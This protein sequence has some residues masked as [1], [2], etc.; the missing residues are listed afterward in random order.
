[1]SGLI[2]IHDRDPARRRALREAF[3]AGFFT[4]AEAA[5]PEAAIALA[6]RRRICLAALEPDAPAPGGAAL[7]RA[8]K[9]HPGFGAAPI[10]PTAAFRRGPEG[11]E[12]RRR[13]ADAGADMTT[14]PGAG[15]LLHAEVRS[16]LRLKTMSDELERRRRTARDLGL[17]GGE[18]ASADGPARR[19][20]I[21][22]VA[23]ASPRASALAA[24]LESKLDAA[25][26]IA[27]A[28][29]AAFRT[30]AFVSPDAI[31]VTDPAGAAGPQGGGFRESGEDPVDLIAALSA[32][33]ET[34]RAAIL[35]LAHAGADADAS[36]AALNAGASEHARLDEGDDEIAS[37]LRFH[38]KRILREDAVRAALDDGLRMA[39]RDQLTGLHDRRYFERHAAQ[40][41]ADRAARPISA[42]VIDI[43][44]F[45]LVND[46]YGHCA[47]DR[48]IA[49][50]ANRLR[51]A[52]RGGDLICRLGG[53][54]FAVLSPATT[55]GEAA[56]AAER[57]RDAV[58]DAL[59]ALSPGVSA[60]L[61]VSVGV[62]TALDMDDGVGPL[63]ER[64]DA[65]LYAAKR[66]GRNQVQGAAA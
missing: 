13:W 64:A 52:L 63:L 8:L 23:P 58:E 4:V 39:V 1:M 6:A 30:A 57:A 11:D 10:V 38:L 41:F 36:A 49:E 18:A 61:T 19:A 22:L 9:A 65:A 12:A 42:M 54:E 32:R 62:A 46:T 55:L 21:M 16:L 43:D 31:I 33:E 3:E 26:S 59:I 20:Q 66:N 50:V 24:A 47:G 45:K 44:R 37:R 29:F 40:L 56:A 14:P 17:D 15:R 51:G 60:R 25:V 28:G 5:T 35:Y 2:L 7:C 53:E 27:A 34:R 48:A